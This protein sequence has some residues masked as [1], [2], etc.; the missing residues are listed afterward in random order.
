MSI[1]RRALVV[2]VVLLSVTACGPAG[3]S[4]GTGTCKPRAEN[5]H[6][7]KGTP[8]DIVGKARITCTVA[9]EEVTLYV[10]LQEKTNGKWQLFREGEPTTV[11]QV[12]IGKIYTAQA[13]A[14][15][16]RGT[17]RTAA[18]GTGTLGGRRAGSM[19]WTYS[20]TVTDPC[21]R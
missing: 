15:C 7:S 18:R 21:K 8:T 10:Q 4:A 20:Q 11:R 16:Q 9:A 19:R 13:E 12:V 2:A 17:F 3:S 14:P 6:Q 5:P 1:L